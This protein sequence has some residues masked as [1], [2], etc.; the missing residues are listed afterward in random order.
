MKLKE[1]KRIPLN[2][3]IE[4]MLKNGVSLLEFKKSKF[5][6]SLS[7][8]FTE[9]RLGYFRG[10]SQ[11]GKSIALNYCNQLV[12]GSPKDGTKQVYLEFEDKNWE[13]KVFE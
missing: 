1:I 8:D 6:P 13:V 4:L 10:I 9:T 2:S 5:V 3:K 7:S 12:D 11:K